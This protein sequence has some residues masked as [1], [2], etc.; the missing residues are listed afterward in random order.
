MFVEVEK[1]NC[2]PAE[3][4]HNNMLLQQNDI[5]SPAVTLEKAN[6][7]TP[8]PVVLPILP[9]SPKISMLAPDLLLAFHK[10]SAD[11][12]SSMLPPSIPSFSGWP[13]CNMHPVLNFKPEMV[14]TSNWQDNKTWKMARVIDRSLFCEKIKQIYV[15]DLFIW[16]NK[17]GP[18]L[19]AQAT[20]EKP[21]IWN[22]RKALSSDNTRVQECNVWWID[23]FG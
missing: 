18:Q 12:Q 13:Y 8:V 3:L 2:V 5:N 20:V 4:E 17:C 6:E 11:L 14:Q 22:C 10:S 21:N 15:Q 23:Y 16:Q 7:A 9:N 19:A 1:P